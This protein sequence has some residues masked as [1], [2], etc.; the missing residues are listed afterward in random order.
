MYIDSHC[1]IN[2]PELNQKIDEVLANMENNKFSCLC[3]SVTL[4]KINEILGLTRNILIFML[5]LGHPDYEDIQEPDID[6]LFNI[7]RIK[8]CSYR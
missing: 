3:V 7:L 4:D 5:P 2:F 1:H 8:S 6:T